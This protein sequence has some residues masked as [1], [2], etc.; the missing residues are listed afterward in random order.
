MGGSNEQANTRSRNNGNDRSLR[1][2]NVKSINDQV[3][4]GGYDIEEPEPGNISVNKIDKN[5]DK[6]CLGSNFTVLQM[7]SR[8]SN[9]YLYDPSYK[10]L[11]NVPIVSG[12]TT[13]T[14][15]ITG[16]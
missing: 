1:A 13:V 8:T 3:T 15:S 9:V 6:Y 14:D 10:L 2:V 7:K 11:Y 4:T 5:A 12:A 16:N